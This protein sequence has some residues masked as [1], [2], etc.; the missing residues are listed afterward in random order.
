[1]AV[2]LPFCHS[3]LFN[4][5]PGYSYFITAPFTN[6]LNYTAQSTRQVPTATMLLVC[7]ILKIH[8]KAGDALL[9]QGLL[10]QA[11]AAELSISVS[12]SPVVYGNWESDCNCL[13]PSPS[14][15]LPCLCIPLHSHLSPAI[16]VAKQ[17]SRKASR[18]T[19]FKNLN[20][21]LL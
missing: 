18:D 14:P 4:I 12:A 21:K 1:M 19:H 6:L 17:T 16:C 8:H 9:K 3:F 20:P 11:E 7:S 15:S 10:L 13:A 2:N 5:I